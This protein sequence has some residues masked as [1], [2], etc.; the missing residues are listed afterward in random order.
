VRE[1]E[2]DQEGEAAWNTICELAQKQLVND[3]NYDAICRHLDVESFIDYCLVY[4]YAGGE[5]WPLNRHNNMK[6][7]C[8]RGQ[9]SPMKF[10]VWDADNTF[11]SGWKHDDCDYVLSIK[12]RNNPKSF[13]AV[14]N[15]LSRNESFRKLIEARLEKWS[16]KGGP[17]NDVVC[18]ERYRK[19]LESIEPALLAESARWGDVQSETP[20]S[21]GETWQTQKNR[22]L[23]QWFSNRAEKVR[24]RL[25]EYWDEL[26][27]SR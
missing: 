15:A 14:F 4:L 19:L 25:R 12:S 6:S 2:A 8:Q 11:A 1:I 27:V 22:I 13:E 5:D 7:Y 23:E 10:L 16:T 9:T 21:P 20:Y 24:I 3:V 17:L 26:N 18:Q